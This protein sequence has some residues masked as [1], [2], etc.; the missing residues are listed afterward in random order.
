MKRNEIPPSVMTWMELENNML[1]KREMA[2]QKDK[3]Y[4]IS[5]IHEIP[6]MLR[7]E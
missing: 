4:M 1:S 6:L 3:H 5:V 7:I 2:G